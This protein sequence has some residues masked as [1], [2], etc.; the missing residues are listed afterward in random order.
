MKMLYDRESLNDR[1][2]L[3]NYLYLDKLSPVGK[4]YGS[5]KGQIIFWG[6]IVRLKISFN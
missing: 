5:Y 3:N 2:I 4:V 6:K 1:K